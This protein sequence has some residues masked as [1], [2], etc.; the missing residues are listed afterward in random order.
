ML[1]A[2]N[3]HG[4]VNFYS[5]LGSANTCT[6]PEV[7]LGREVA[8]INLTVA[9]YT[10]GSA[11]MAFYDLGPITSRLLGS[12][13][14]AS[15]GEVQVAS[16]TGTLWLIVQP[17]DPGPVPLAFTLRWRSSPDLVSAPIN[18]DVPHCAY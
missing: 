10:L 3:I 14:G 16:S 2:L 11:V 1:L 6:S 15:A 12:L 8:F 13:S 7:G 9:N 18:S 5:L 17:R 4:G